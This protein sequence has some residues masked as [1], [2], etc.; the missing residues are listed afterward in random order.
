M[1]KLIRISGPVVEAESMGGAAMYDVVKVGKEELTGEIIKMVGD[2][3]TVQ[4]PGPLLSNVTSDA[5][6]G[7]DAPG[8]PLERDECLLQAV[9][10]RDP[11]RQTGH[12]VVQGLMHQ[13][14]FGLHLGADVA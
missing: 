8:T 1:G 11:V 12:R 2:T 10:H 5:G 13:C 7:T 14:L 3:S 6:P 4:F 9:H